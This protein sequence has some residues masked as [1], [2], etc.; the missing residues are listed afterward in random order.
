MASQAV[1][2]AKNQAK[3]CLL[4]CHRKGKLAGNYGLAS[5]LELEG[6]M[7]NHMREWIAGGRTLV[8]GS[9]G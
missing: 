1:F 9:Q 7:R 6:L 4:N 3:K 2:Q 5:T 8:I